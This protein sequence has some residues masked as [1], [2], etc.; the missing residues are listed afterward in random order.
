MKRLDSLNQVGILLLAA[1]CIWQWRR[2]YDLNLEVNRLEKLG[3][4]QGAKLMEQE[5]ARFGLAEDLANLKVQFGRLETQS[6]DASQKFRNGSREL[7]QISSER[8]QLKTSISNWVVAVATRDERLRQANEQ[9]RQLADELNS[10]IHK[11]NE[12]ATNHN[13]RVKELNEL[14]AQ[15]AKPQNGK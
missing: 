5:K 3:L 12:L 6:N 11:F 8:D 15:L 13:A 14:H 10:S 2:D 7:R 4:E 1:L 9:T